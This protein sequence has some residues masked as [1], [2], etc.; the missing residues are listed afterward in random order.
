MCFIRCSFLFFSL[1]LI[2]CSINPDK[3]LNRSSKKEE[4]EKPSLVISNFKTIAYKGDEIIWKLE[5]D[6]SSVYNKKKQSFF[7]DVYFEIYD[8][9]GNFAIKIKSDNGKLFEKSDDVELT[10]NV[11]IQTADNEK[12]VSDYFYWD[13]DTEIMHAPI[14]HFVTLTK[15]DGTKLHGYGARIDMNE[16][17]FEFISESSGVVVDDD[18]S[19]D[20][21]NL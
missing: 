17:S 14:K 13:N 5:A 3:F 10:N 16:E 7:N 6:E 20:S 11:L 1:V 4:E 2:N 8:R 19:P 9:D 15:P 18:I 21:T 12:I